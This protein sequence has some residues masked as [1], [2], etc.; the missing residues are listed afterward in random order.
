MSFVGRIRA[1]RRSEGGFTLVEMLAALMVFSIATL[2]IVPLLATSIHGSAISRSYTV[3]KNL[4]QEAMERIRGLSFFVSYASQNKRVDVLDLYYP[5]LGTGYSAG[6]FTT[7]CTP[8][9]TNPACPKNLPTG[10]TMTFKATFVR[11]STYSTTPTT[12]AVVLPSAGYRWDSLTGADVPP[13]QMLELSVTTDWEMMSGDDKTLTMKTLLADRKVGTTRVRGTG[14]VDYAIQVLTG[15][16]VSGNKSSLK[17]TGASGESKVETKL[18][19]TANQATSAGYLRLLR[20][21]DDTSVLGTDIGTSPMSGASTVLAAPPDTTPAGTTAGEQFLKHSDWVSG[22]S[23]RTVAWLDDSNTSTLKATVANELPS[24]SGFARTP[25]NV[26][27]AAWV[28]NQAD[29]TSDSLLQVEGGEPMIEIGR[30]SRTMQAETYATTTAADAASRVVETIADA[31]LGDV[32]ITPVKFINGS[33]DHVIRISDFAARAT[34]RSTASAATASATGT[35]TATLRYWVDPTNDGS[36]NGAYVTESLT[37]AT[38]GSRLES[39]QASNPLVNDAPLA[40]DDVYLFQTSTR[41][42]YLTD[43]GATAPTVSKSA[44]GRVTNVNLDG[45]IRLDTSPTNQA[46]ADSVMSVSIGKMSCE[47]VDNR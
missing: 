24:S 9:S 31:K 40:A 6:V 23:Q 39:I 1:R 35:W 42:G 16:N 41:Q 15:Y 30:T 4:T 18:L 8:T 7:N 19:S 14:R 3:N 10:T 45:A 29:A 20:S 5:N 43:W 13:S 26:S 44:D 32:R 34:C 25:S 33:D 11:T 22:G 46:I 21:S 47:A 28:T 17:F 38:A 37:A 36:Y 2:G 12:Y 27:V